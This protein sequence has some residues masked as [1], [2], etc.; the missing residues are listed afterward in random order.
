MSVAARPLDISAFSTDRRSRQRF[1]LTLAVEYRLLGKGERC[2]SGKTRNISSSGLLFEVADLLPFSGLIELMLSWPCV[3]NGA[4]ALK[5]M[6][7]GRVV[8]SEGRGIAIES[9]QYEFRT[10]GLASVMRAQDLRL[11]TLTP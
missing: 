6:M 1:P 4:C 10:A 3:L 11:L 2:G 9:S 5:L 7:K 8:R